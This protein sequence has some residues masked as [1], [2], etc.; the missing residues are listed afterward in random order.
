MSI[1]QDSWNHC[2]QKL[3]ASGAF[4]AAWGSQGSGDGQF[5]SPTGIAVDDAGNMYVADAQNK[6]IQKF[7][8]SGAFVAKWTGVGADSGGLSGA[9]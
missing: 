3:T 5:L 6:R 7:S 9:I 4:V 8:A 1:W 2:I